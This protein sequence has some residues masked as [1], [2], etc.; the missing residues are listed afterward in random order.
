MNREVREAQEE[1]SWVFNYDPD[2]PIFEKI[3]KRTGY[4]VYSAIMG[5]V[6]FIMWLF[7]LLG[8]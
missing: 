8:P 4:L 1:K 7:A 5:V 3:A 2:A 6:T